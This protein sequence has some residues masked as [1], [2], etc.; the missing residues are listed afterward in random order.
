MGVGLSYSPW[1][2]ALIDDINL[3]YLT[4]YKKVG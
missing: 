3:A 1:L 2:R 4:G